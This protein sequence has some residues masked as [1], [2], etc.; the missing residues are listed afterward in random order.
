[1]TTPKD[2]KVFISHASKDEAIVRK[3]VELLEDIGLS[4]AQVV[5]SSVPGYGIPLGEDIYDWLAHQF[6]E[7]DLHVLF[8]LSKNYYNS[9]ACQNEMAAAWVQKT[10]YDT[11]L[12]PGFEFRDIKGA[13]N[14]NQISIKLDGNEEV[15]K[16][17]LNELKDKLVA[18]FQLTMP[19]ASKWERHRQSFIASIA[20]LPAQ[21]DN[22]NNEPDDIAPVFDNRIKLTPDAE[23]LLIEAVNDPY[24]RITVLKVMSGTFISANNESFC[25]PDGGPRLEAKWMGALEELEDCGLVQAASYKR[26]VFTVTREGY[27]YAD[28]ITETGISAI[29]PVRSDIDD[30][31]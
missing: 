3:I 26:E 12:L 22:E 1:M 14:P 21:E 4:E 6:R 24:G 8:M 10:I 30:F 28:S 16:Q 7:Y 13:V 31:L 19:S 18:E 25:Y 2:K 15:L 20:S 5:C 17:H 9:I 27:D 23:K 29:A 11:I